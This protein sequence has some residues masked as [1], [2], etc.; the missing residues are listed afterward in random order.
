MAIEFKKVTWYSQT[1]A[2]VLFVA[3]FFVG[4]AL[5]SKKYDPNAGLRPHGCERDGRCGVGHPLD[6]NDADAGRD[7]FPD[8]NRGNLDAALLNYSTTTREGHVV[9]VMSFKYM[10]DGG[11]SFVE[12]YANTS[13][14]VPLNSGGASREATSNTVSTVTVTLDTGK[15]F[16]LNPAMSASGAFHSD[17]D[18][19]FKFWSKG[20][21][22]MIEQSGVMTYQN[23]VALN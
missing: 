6:G 12:T 22:A 8:S 17:S 19:S 14:P 7:G 18:A 16:A 15:S 9:E 20:E 5:G 2:V 3:V 11:K 23:C 1:L 13:I 4:Y 21:G 10:C